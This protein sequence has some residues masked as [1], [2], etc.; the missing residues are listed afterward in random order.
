MKMWMNEGEIEQA[1]ERF[2]SHPV[3]GKGARF[4]SAFQDEVNEHS[5]G[6]AYWK[7]PAKAAEKLVALLHGHL[8]GGMGAYPRLPEPTDADLKKAIAPIKAFYT[9]RGYKAGMKLPEVR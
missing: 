1:V 9:R 5:D 3:L 6:W 7:L 8:Y 2:K 4:L